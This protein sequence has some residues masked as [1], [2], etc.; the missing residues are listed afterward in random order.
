MPRVFTAKA[1]K[2]YPAHNIVKGQ[3]YYHWS[4]FRGPKQ[5]SA[6]RPRPSQ[7]TGNSKLCSLYSAG[8][9]F[10]DVLPTLMTPEDISSALTEYA[11]AVRSVAEEYRDS[12]TNMEGAFPGGSPTIDEFN[13]NADNL[14]AFAEEL[15]E[16]AATIAD[17]DAKDFIDEDE[18]RLAIADQLEREENEEG[19]APWDDAEVESYFQE[20]LDGIG[21]FEDLAPSEQVEMLDEARDCARGPECPL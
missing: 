15:E 10:E 2:D 3:T 4:T 8:E 7:V 1:A 13:D 19:G 21:G 16:A 20:M 6:T 17:R 5:M 12:V 14:D 18:R 11:D 9:A